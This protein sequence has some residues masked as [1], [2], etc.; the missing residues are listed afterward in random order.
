M[1]IYCRLSCQSELRE[2]ADFASSFAAR[3]RNDLLATLDDL[4]ATIYRDFTYTPELTALE[5]TPFEIYATRVGVCQDFANLMI[6]AA[7]LLNVPARYRV[8]YVL[9]GQAS[10]GDGEPE[11]SHAW[12]ELYLPHLGWRGYDPT[13]GSRVQ[14]SHVRV[15]CGRNYRDA[16]PTAGV[17]YGGRDESLE[18]DVHVEDRT[19]IA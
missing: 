4:N 15:A 9:A 3:N 6:C 13:S 8:G 14:T 1:R 12:V 11:A 10:H 7:R 2:L 16:T 5:T 17:I 19:A 18:I